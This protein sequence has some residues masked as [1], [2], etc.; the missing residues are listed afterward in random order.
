MAVGEKGKAPGEEE[1]ARAL[2]PSYA[3]LQQ[4]L[5]EY[6][7]LRPEWKYY[8]QKHGW[9]LKLFEKKRNLC[10]VQP[11]E[12]HFRV[13]F[14]LGARQAA[15]ALASNLPA[16]VKRE[17]AEARQYAEGRG[18]SVSVQG[19]EHLAPVRQLLAIKR[20]RAAPA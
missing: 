3:V 4:L 17:L 19:P 6:A 8:G 12:G 1:L 16:E 9:S 14:A 11:R 13:A 2:G 18:V 20:D 5:A 10:F 15:T 7:E